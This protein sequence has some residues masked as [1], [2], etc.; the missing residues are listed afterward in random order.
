M[1]ISPFPVFV[2]AISAAISA[3][4]AVPERETL[5]P[6]GKKGVL[7]FTLDDGSADHYDTAAPALERHG[8]RGIFNI[9][10]ARIGTPGYMNWDQ[11]R[12]LVKRGHELGNHSWSHPNLIRLM[13][14]GGVEAVRSEIRR[15][16]DAIKAETGF[17]AKTVCYPGN[18]MNAK[19]DEVIR[20]LGFRPESYR[21]NSWG[22][23]GGMKAAEFDVAHARKGNYCFVLLHG[24]RPGP[25]SGWQALYDAKELDRILD[26]VCTQDDIWIAGYSEAL[27]WREGYYNRRRR[28]SYEGEQIANYG[29][30]AVM[31][32]ILNKGGWSAVRKPGEVLE[33]K[34]GFRPFKPEIASSFKDVT[35]KI[36]LAGDDGKIIAE[37]EVPFGTNTVVTI[38]G[39]RDAPGDLQVTVEVPRLKDFQRT[40]TFGAR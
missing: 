30:S 40:V 38:S 4:A 6:Q 3:T 14:T 21:G 37:K 16:Y 1:R 12:D 22:G 9:I 35:A 23:R 39:T 27:D 32:E 36:R 7:V 8:I 2:A 18:A 19:T 31:C 11:V 34:V 33:F 28:L 24:V 13:E 15:G 29:R 20:E 17:D 10:P 26:W 25:G 5:M